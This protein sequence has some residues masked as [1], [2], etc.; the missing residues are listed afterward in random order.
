MWFGCT[1]PTVCDTHCH[2]YALDATAT[3]GHNTYGATAH[4]EN[5]MARQSYQKVLYQLFHIRTT[6]PLPHKDHSLL[7]GIGGVVTG[8]CYAMFLGLSPP[9]TMSVVSEVSEWIR[10]AILFALGI[11]FVARKPWQPSNSV[12]QR[13]GRILSIVLAASS[14]TVLL[15]ALVDQT[16]YDG[17]LASFRALYYYIALCWLGL[18]L[19]RAA[20]LGF[21]RFA[22]MLLIGCMMLAVLPVAGSTSPLSV[23]ILPF[24]QVLAVIMAGLIIHW[25]AGFIIAL[26]LPIAMAGIGFIELQTAIPAQL[27]AMTVVQLLMIATVV[28]LYA[29][30]LEAAL[31]MA[32]RQTALAE[33]VRAELRAQHTQLEQQA[34]ELELARQQLRATIDDQRQQLA[35]A[36]TTQHQKTDLAA[37]VTPLSEVAP[38]V[39]VAPVLGAWNNERATQFERQALL[40]IEQ[41]RFRVLVLDMSGADTDDGE[42][43]AMLGRVVEAVYFLGC[44]IVIVGIQPEL[45]QTLARQDTRWPAV[46][47]AP[48]L[49]EGVALAQHLS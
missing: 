23:Q 29:R 13:K 32:E 10:T 34:A 12:Q 35:T 36:T 40:K 28:A 15:T 26:V 9:P 38:G 5:N 3:I 39:A 17:T 41:H 44:R 46:A 4:Y 47:I 22:A 33:A 14:A 45:A 19:W 20:L 42:L 18:L 49:L 30:S 25:S 16:L 6:R 48:T 37:L 24:I 1:L 43:A 21:S 8:M 2:I 7:W 31:G 11:W 27:Q